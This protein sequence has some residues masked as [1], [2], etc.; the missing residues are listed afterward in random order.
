M[1]Q[2]NGRRGHGPRCI[3][4]VGP[5]GSGKTSLLEALLW[6]S[7]AIPRQGHVSQGNTVGDASAEARAHVMSV[8]TNIAECEF[9]GEPFTF[10]EC[11]G[12]V[13]FLTE[14]QGV[15]PGVDVAVVVCEADEKKLPALQVVLKELEERSIPRILFLNKI[16]KADARV[17]ET[18]STLQQASE[19]PL[20]LRQIPIWE[21]GIAT[22]FIDLALERAFVY[23]EHAASE[24]V[25]MSDGDHAREEEARFTMLEQLADYDDALMEQLLEDIPPP[26]DTVFDDLVSEMRDGLIVPVLTGSAEEAHGTMRLLKAIRHE[27][28]GFEETADRLGVGGNGDTVVQVLKTIHTTHA[29]KLSLVR[30]LSGSVKDGDFLHGEDGTEDKVSGV[31]RVMGQQV[32]KREPAT[33]GET[34]AL[35]KLDHARTGATLTSAKAGIVQ[36]AALTPPQPV[37]AKAIVPTERKDEVK[38]SA[39]IAKIAEEDPSL[40][41]LHNQ[42]TGETLLEGQGEM[43]L[44]V[45]TERLTGKY[46]LSIETHQPQIPYRET[47]R[48]SVTL[49]GRHKKQT[50]GHGQFGDVVLEISALPRGSGFQ[51]SDR[52]TGGVVP[53][54]YIPSVH[55]GVE[56]YLRQGPLG[57]E[58]VDISV[59]LTDGSFHTVDSSDMAFKMAAQIAMREGMPQCHP[60]LLE[61]V[62]EIEIVCPNEAT[63]KVNA[64]V[65]GRRGQ[66]LGFDTRPGWEGWD[67]VKAMMPQ[68]EISDLIV[69]LRSATAGVGTFTYAFDHLA[70]LSGRQADQVI[71]AQAER[72]KAR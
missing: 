17:R 14:M 49:R 10:V 5:F 57:F 69:E 50:G 62:L 28:P 1:G 16:D 15:L 61:P 47:I 42:D 35:G 66:I 55:H 36:A 24:I 31:F 51:F 19:R 63:A 4:L 3:A 30:V 11:P 52:I 72:L 56:D 12:S 65:S 60:V 41:I 37:M 32:T 34:V 39:A 64:I 23:R 54:Q 27:A 68:S 22:G 26:R 38:L 20:V 6:R 48:G 40:V 21:N 25:E 13:E 33:V 18:L 53:K 7:G 67:S 45:T 71:A 43:H 9:M 29:G 2:D 44:R 8:E 70:E 46:G 59:C 58:V